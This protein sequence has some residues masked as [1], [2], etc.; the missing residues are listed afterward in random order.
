MHLEK[1]AP[2]RKPYVVIEIE[3]AATLLKKLPASEVQQQA[4]L[5]S[6]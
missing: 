1:I 6:S 2:N 3:Q 5:I 4:E